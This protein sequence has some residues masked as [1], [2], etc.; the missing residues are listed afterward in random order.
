MGDGKLFNARA[1]D[2]RIGDMLLSGLTLT[3]AY[4][5]IDLSIMLLPL[6]DVCID[7]VHYVHAGI[8]SRYHIHHMNVL[9]FCISHIQLKGRSHRR[10]L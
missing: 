6:R 10:R 1:A 4:R 7:A 2:Q 8:P 3:I 9:Q 5:F